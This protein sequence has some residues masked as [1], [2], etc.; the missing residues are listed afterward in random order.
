[1]RSAVQSC[2]PLQESDTTESSVVFFVCQGASPS[3]T[4]SYTMRAGSQW[5]T[6]EDGMPQ[7]IGIQKTSANSPPAFL[8]NRHLRSKS[9]LEG[10]TKWRLKH[11]ATLYLGRH[12]VN[13]DNHRN[14]GWIPLTIS[15]LN[16]EKRLY[17]S[18]MC[19]EEPHPTLWVAFS[20]RMSRFFS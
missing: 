8:G 20:L 16:P 14:F 2:D 1:M 12:E 13:I 9:G 3:R 7:G 5:D 10:A 4:K 15:I 17:F 18:D 11:P 6:D 19:A